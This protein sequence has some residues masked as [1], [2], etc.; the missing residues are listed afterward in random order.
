M[1]QWPETLGIAALRDA[2]L[3]ETF[4]DIARIEYIA[5][6]F[7]C[8]LHPQVDLATEYRWSRIN[9][10][11]GEMYNLRAIAEILMQLPLNAGENLSGIC[12]GPPFQ[13]PYTLDSPLGEANRWRMHLDLL[14]AA[15][16]LI[17]S[18]L[19]IA[20]A[21]RHTYLQAMREADRLMQ[22]T[23]ERILAGHANLALT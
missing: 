7:R 19:L 18:L 11:F 3:T 9:A 5:L 4:A 10:T 20:P 8:A 23:A 22:A 15:E 6:G 14:S 17:Q 21:S 13:M 12:A 1:S 16:R 2:K